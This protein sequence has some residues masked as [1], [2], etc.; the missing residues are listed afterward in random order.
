MVKKVIWSPR[1]VKA[2]DR[3]ITYLTIKWTSKEIEKFIRATHKT[4]EQ[5]SSGKIQFRRS[6]KRNIY[7]VLVTKHNLLL[8]RVQK[9]SIELLTFFDTRQSPRKKR[10]E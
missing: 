1:A 3:I 10:L 7:E 6:N 4:I 9:N 2:H 8:Y 5:I